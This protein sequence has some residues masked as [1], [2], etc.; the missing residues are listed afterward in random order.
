MDVIFRSVVGKLWMT[1]IALFALVLTIFS[2]LLVQSFDSYYFHKQ[3]EDLIG[4]SLRLARTIEK[5]PSSRKMM[6]FSANLWAAYR[7][8]LIVVD[9][10]LRPLNSNTSSPFLSGLSIDELIHR[11]ELELEQVL[12]GQKPHPARIIISKEDGDPSERTQILAVAAPLKLEGKETGAV[13]MFQPIEDFNGTVAEVRKL[14]FVVG[15]IGF[16]LTTV[17]AFFLSSRITFP[18]RQMKQTA[19]RIAEGDFDAKVTHPSTDEIG[20][21]AATFNTMAS[22]LNEVIHALSN[23]KEQLSSV[24]KNMVDGVIM[25]DAEGKIVVTNP[26]AEHFLR[27]WKYERNNESTPIFD[28][29][30]RVL[31]TEKEIHEDIPV[32]GRV[33]TVVMVPLHDREMV[34][35]ALA[36]LRDMT[37]ERKL[38]KLRKDFVANVSHELRTPL[39]M[40]Q[41]Y[42]EA[43]VDDIAA[44]PEEHKELAKIIYDESVRMTKLVNELLDLA[45]MEAGHTELYKDTVVLRPYLERIHRKFVNL[46]KDRG[47]NLELSYQANVEQFDLD[48]DRIEQVL[49]NLIDNAM[50]H[51]PAGGTVKILAGGTDPLIL[52][53]SD[54][55]SGIPQE[56]LPFVFERFYKADKARTRGR[57]GTGLGLAIAKNIVEAHD[58][59]ITVHSKLGEGTT[60]T[61]SLPSI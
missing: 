56:D 4:L 27:D 29:Y 33:W 10:Q 17:F 38:D 48:A 52:E 46:A 41:G 13:I 11:P 23:E 12:A 51:T 36:V 60:F 6:D 43:I 7:T 1:I 35:G 47:I 5:V 32:Q 61:I 9:G 44:S 24:L 28:M 57:A 49:T 30:Q 34:R 14:I 54:T 15:V 58:G 50:R 8:G 45:R 42:S 25:I 53:I 2:L 20:E 16:I 21:L 59:T 19:Q 22:R 55:G 39:S 3:T 40:L 37:K 18:L 31:Q 26:P